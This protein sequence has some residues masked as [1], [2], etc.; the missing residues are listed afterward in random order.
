MKSL[1][2]YAGL[3]FVCFLPFH[4]SAQDIFSSDLL[5]IHIHFAEPGWRETLTMAKKAGRKDRLTA[6]VEINNTV[7][8]G[9]QVRFKGNSSFNAAVRAGYRKLPLNLKAPDGASFDGGYETLKLA[10][11]FRDPSMV[12]EVLAYRIAG[13]YVPV[14]ATTC[15]VVSVDG[16]YLG[17]YTVTEDV[18]GD[19]AKR[20][21]CKHKHGLV[22]CEPDFHA[23]VSPGCPPGSYASLEYLGDDPKCYQRL[24]QVKK[25]DEWPSLIHLMR[26]LQDTPDSIPDF[27]D[28]H[29][30]LWMDAINNVLVNLDSY[31]GFFC[32]NYY[33]YRDDRDVYHPL[34]WDLNLAFGGFHVLTGGDE[35]DMPHLS[36]LVHEHTDLERRPLVN[37]LLKNP[38]YRRIYF[39]M[40]RTMLDDWFLNGKY[41][42][43]ATQLQDRIRPYVMQ[44]QEPFVSS[45]DFDRSLSE[46]VEADGYPVIGIGQLMSLR[47]RYLDALP[48]LQIKP[49]EVDDWHAEAA[50]DS[51]VIRIQ[52]NGDPKSVELWVRSD[53]H[54]AFTPVKMHPIPPTHTFYC[55]IYG[56]PEAFYW[57]LEGNSSANLWPLHAPVDVITPDDH[58]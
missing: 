9:V 22:E 14:P 15:A 3:V 1:L 26:V 35:I 40:I 44:E 50:G 21:F 25:D 24:Y 56:K 29:L 36:P 8:E 28:V 6:T 42:E 39:S 30:T 55:K 41:L 38:S 20:Y 10:N 7:Y 17:V 4:L 58:D 2:W 51:T 11:N 19:L 12:R 57:V 45:A 53:Q 54:C 23:P 43:V 34:L 33:L 27:L 16:E 5:E 49:L 13:T 48:Y 46:T 37:V 31:L 47:T 52:T 32:H 18:D